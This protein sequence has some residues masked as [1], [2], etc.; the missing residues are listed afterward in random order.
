LIVIIIRKPHPSGAVFLLNQLWI[1]N[2]IIDYSE[3]ICNPDQIPTKDVKIPIL[4]KGGEN[5][6]NF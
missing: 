6:K 1:L 2:C 3:G 4:W 5:S